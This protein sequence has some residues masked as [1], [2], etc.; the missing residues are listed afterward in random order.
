MFFKYHFFAQLK[1]KFNIFINLPVKPA[2][3]TLTWFIMTFQMCQ[4]LWETRIADCF[5]ILYPQRVLM[6]H[7]QVYGSN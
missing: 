6:L 3:P 4:N 5:K 7:S 2:L 1:N